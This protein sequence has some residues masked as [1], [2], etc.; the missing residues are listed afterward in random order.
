MRKERGKMVVSSF[1]VFGRFLG[2]EAIVFISV[3]K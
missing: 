2:N 3:K 1:F